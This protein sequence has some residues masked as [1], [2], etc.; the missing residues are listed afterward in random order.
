MVAVSAVVWCLTVADLAAVGGALCKTLLVGENSLSLSLFP[1][2]ASKAQ[3]ARR[4]I[5]A[6][7]FALNELL[8]GA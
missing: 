3:R 5:V 6:K 7:A 8:Q 2:N 1:G 4:L